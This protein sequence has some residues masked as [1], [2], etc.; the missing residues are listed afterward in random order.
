MKKSFFAI[1]SVT[2]ALS[3]FSWMSCTKKKFEDRDLPLVAVGFNYAGSRLTV[4]SEAAYSK[5]G[6]MITIPVDISFTSSASTLF[7]LNVV[8]RPDT[9]NK[10]ITDNVLLNTVALPETAYTFATAMDVRYGL[11]K[12]PVNVQMTVS[13][14]ERF[15][16]KDV[17]FALTITNVSKGNTITSEKKTV[18]VVVDT[19]KIIDLADVH[20]VSFKESGKLISINGGLNYTQD[21]DYVNIPFNVSL[22]GSVGPAL[23]AGLDVNMDTAQKI[24]AGG[25]IANAVAVGASALDLTIKSNIGINENLGQ[26]S[27]RIRTAEIAKY[28][29]KNLV[30]G[31]RLKD[32]SKYQVDPDNST[33]VVVVNTLSSVKNITALMKNTTRP[34][35]ST[36]W[37]KRRWG[38]LDDWTTTSPVINQKQGPNTSGYVEGTFGGFDKNNNTNIAMQSG[39]TTPAAPNITNGKIYQT[40]NLPAGQYRVTTTCVLG[41][42]TTAS[43]AFYVAAAS[44]TTLPDIPNFTTAPN[45]VLGTTRITSN[46]AYEFSFTVATTSQVTIGFI[47]TISGSTAFNISDIKLYNVIP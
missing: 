24:V 38:N 45:P 7:T 39:F 34:F 14:L 20:Y 9:V 40:V 28:F 4:E 43:Q 13:D 10:L 26:G 27:F 33:L 32:P 12:I 3:I 21:D 41:S 25:T 46:K 6:D 2:A 29:G 47:G 36:V 35:Q 5:S 31:V 44:G 37:D 19:K 18:I 16:G 30:I 1:V 8:S 22:A 15:Y 23:T 17:A 42:T 11:N